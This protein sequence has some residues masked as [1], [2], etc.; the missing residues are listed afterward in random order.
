M[1]QV[2]NEV[3]ALINEAD[4]CDRI[5]TFFYNNEDCSE[6]MNKI[7]RLERFNRLH[8]V[9]RKNQIAYEL[10]AWEKTFE[11]KNIKTPNGVGKIQLS[12]RG[13]AFRESNGKLTPAFFIVIENDRWNTHLY[14]IDELE[15][16]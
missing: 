6:E 11:G 13:I 7:Y 14:T 12:E 8:F 5:N 1:I 10:T 15:V 9:M 16:L 4:S 2:N 3:Q